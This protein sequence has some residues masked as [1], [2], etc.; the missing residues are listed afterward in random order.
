M[1][2]DSAVGKS[3]TLGAHYAA[4]A[5]V[6]KL[7]KV[8]IRR[9][10]RPGNRE[11]DAANIKAVRKF[12]APMPFTG[13]VWR[14]RMTVKEFVRPDPNG[15]RIYTLEIDDIRAP[16]L[17]VQP[18]SQVSHIHEQSTHWR[19]A[20][21]AQMVKNVKGEVKPGRGQACREQMNHQMMTQRASFSQKV[22][23]LSNN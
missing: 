16:V 11:E 5:N 8:A 13:E 4:V 21:F 15:D 10:R 12:D 3:V 2:D 6:D 19:K 14:V 20:R 18:S 22:N 17:S 7:F 23:D 9:S 1:V